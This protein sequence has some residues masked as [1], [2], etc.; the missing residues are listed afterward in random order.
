MRK[1]IKQSEFVLMVITEPYS[2]RFDGEEILGTGKGATY[3]G[4]IINQ[5]IYNEQC[6]NGKFI[7]VVF[8][9]DARGSMPDILQAVTSYNVLKSGEYRRML[10]VLTGQQLT[11]KPALGT[12]PVLAGC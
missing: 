3:E 10:S 12:V 2:R 11:P 7:P 4:H 9:D 5:Q 8:S 6:R 1:Q